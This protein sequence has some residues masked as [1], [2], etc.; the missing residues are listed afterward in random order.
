MEFEGWYDINGMVVDLIPNARN[1]FHYE[2]LSSTS[3]RYYNF[4]QLYAI[5]PI[6]HPL[7]IF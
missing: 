3:L 7:K 5:Y 4:I 1:L 6:L 2:H